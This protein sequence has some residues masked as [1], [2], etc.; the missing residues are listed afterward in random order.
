MSAMTAEAF[1]LRAPSGGARSAGF[2]SGQR[3]SGRP[4]PVRPRRQPNARPARG[5]G[6][7]A[8]PM[9]R[10]AG[11]VPA[12]RL[13]PAVRQAPQACAVEAEAHWRLTDRGIAV[14]MVTGLMIV[15]AAVMVVSMTAIRV[16]GDGYQ[17]H[18]LS[19]VAQ[20]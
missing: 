19:Q 6:R 1:D 11:A 10:P 2:A 12:P 17:T 14:I 8:R 16:T 7:S 4:M 15:A 5:T 3:S 18:S 13:A 9:A 20:S